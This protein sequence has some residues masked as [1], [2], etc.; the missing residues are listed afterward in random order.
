MTGATPFTVSVTLALAIA[1]P[2]VTPNPG[3]YS[4]SGTLAMQTAS[5]GASIYYT[6]NGWPPTQSS[7]LYTGAKTLAS[8]AVIKTKAFKSGFNL[9]GKAS[10]SSSFASPGIAKGVIR[11]ADNLLSRNCT[12]G[13]YSIAN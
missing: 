11:Y 13:N 1:I 12:S 4:G 2:T 10:A 3:D 9:S 8:N 6:T 5:S 7:T